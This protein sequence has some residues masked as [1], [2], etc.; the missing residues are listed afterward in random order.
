LSGHSKKSITS[1]SK[2]MMTPTFKESVKNLPSPFGDGKSSK[3]ILDI[4]LDFFKRGDLKV[5]EKRK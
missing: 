3:R 4:T 2:S 1:L 5:P